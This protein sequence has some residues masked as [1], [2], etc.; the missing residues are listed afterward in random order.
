MYITKGVYRYI[1]VSGMRLKSGPITKRYVGCAE[2]EN[3][4]GDGLYA[5]SVF[6]NIQ[7]KNKE[8]F[9]L[10]H[11]I[12]YYDERNKVTWTPD[13]IHFV[14][15]DYIPPLLFPAFSPSNNQLGRVRQCH[16]RMTVG[17]EYIPFA[18]G[19]WIL[20]LAYIED[21]VDVPQEIRLSWQPESHS[22]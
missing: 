7:I 11:S 15:L 4:T 16:E 2:T 1:G 5:C 13:C 20:E 14:P 18:S 21:Y 19:I 17:E 22:A 12:L 6:Y 3:D 10:V 8:Y 9:G